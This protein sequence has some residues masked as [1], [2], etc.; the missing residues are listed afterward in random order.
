MHALNRDNITR[1]LL[2][3]ALACVS[4]AICS[5]FGW[6][7]VAVNVTGFALLGVF[8]WLLSLVL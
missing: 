8:F 5:T 2:L 3:V 7:G 4:L 1:L 6:F